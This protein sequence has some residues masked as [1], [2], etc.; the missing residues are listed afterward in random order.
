M[1]AKKKKK[2]KEKKSIKKSNHLIYLTHVDKPHP[3]K[4]TN[5][6]ALSAGA[7]IKL[8]KKEE[9]KKKRGKGKGGKK[10]TTQRQVTVHCTL[11]ASKLDITQPRKGTYIKKK[12][13]KR[14]THMKTQ[15]KKRKEKNLLGASTTHTQRER[16]REHT[17]I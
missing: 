5:P 10:R 15:K 2:E 6:H 14:T 17:G 9:Q 11:K 4:Q 7:K 13:K 3:T 1:L 16:E 8:K 12:V